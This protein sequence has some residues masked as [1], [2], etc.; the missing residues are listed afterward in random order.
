MTLAVACTHPVQYH[1]PVFRAVHRNH[2]VPVHVIYGS[3]F[4]IR[5]YFD[6]EFQ[7]RFAWDV[8]LVAEEDSC[9]FLGNAEDFDEVSAR[10]IGRALERLKPGALL[11]TGYSKRFHAHAFWAARRRGIPVLFRAETTDHASLRNRAKALARDL[12]LRNFYRCCR[13]LLPI[14][15]RSRAHYVRLGCPDDKLI[16]SAYCVDTAPFRTDEAARSELRDATRGELGIG[17]DRTV[18][19]FCGKL[20]RR[21][22][23]DVLVEAA[24][25]LRRD[26]VLLFVGEGED[27]DALRQRAEA[28]GVEA[29]FAGFQNQTHLSRFY[30]A[31]DL[32]AMPSIE[33]ET[34]GLAV[35]E[36]LHHGVPCVA[37]TAVGSVDD[38]IE[39]GVTGELAEP[40][41]ADG[42]AAAL[43]RAMGLRSTAHRAACRAAVSRYTVDDAAAGIARAYLNVIENAA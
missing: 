6:A 32:F 31:A 7:Q 1:A 12:L 16:A 20:R 3:D 9:T 4:S 10:G 24:A 27:R 2:G 19:L 23:L 5:G 40:G 18:V 41:S 39:P 25:V 8:P 30:H 15:S 28:I 43:L 11:L 26:I 37:S 36:A 38:L 33:S 22:G 13:Y 35:N 42:F 34:W 21:K 17:P 14:G 29:R